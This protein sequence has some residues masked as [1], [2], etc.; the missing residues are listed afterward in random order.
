MKIKQF[1]Q[2]LALTLVLLVTGAQVSH[3]Q[4]DCFTYEYGSGNTI[5]T[6]LTDSGEAAE[7]LTIPSTVNTVRSGSFYYARTGVSPL[8]SLTIDGGNPVFEADL[9]DE[10]TSTLSD[11]FTGKGMTT[12]NIKNL[13]LSLGTGSALTTVNIEGYAD[14]STP[15]DWTDSDIKAVLT[16]D[17]KVVLPAELVGNQVFGDAKVYGRF[18]IEKEIISFCCNTTFLDNDDGSNMLFYV[19]DGIVDNKIHIQRVWYLAKGQGLLIHRTESGGGYADL[20]RIGDISEYFDDQAEADKTSYS[21]NKLVGVTTP[22][23][24]TATEGEGAY[25]YT[26]LVLKDGT[27]YRTSGG[28]IKANRAYLHVLTSS[29]PSTASSLEIDFEDETYINEELRIKNEESYDRE[30]YTLD[31]RKLSDQPTTHG[32]YIHNGKKIMIK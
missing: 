20:E 14:T 15:I 25:E 5:I 22:T 8:R 1:I 29:L 16:E 3:A 7:E 27:F 2:Q 13:L 11:I 26:N 18:S 30:W 6:G 10:R 24:I 31:G 28:T 19:A 4:S 9:F 23:P 21:A 17:V 32:I 12:T